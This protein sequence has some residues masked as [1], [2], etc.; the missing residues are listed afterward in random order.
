MN[1][2]IGRT[3]LSMDNL[4]IKGVLSIKNIDMLETANT[5]LYK[6]IHISK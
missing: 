6:C 2:A 1:A 4:P 3:Q 5:H